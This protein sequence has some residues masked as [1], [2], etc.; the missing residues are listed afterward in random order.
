MATNIQETTLTFEFDPHL[1]GEDVRQDERLRNV[2]TGT[3]VTDALVA[4]FNGVAPLI[5][6]PAKSGPTIKLNELKVA[7]SFSVTRKFDAGLGDTIVLI[8]APD[9]DSLGPT[10][11]RSREQTSVYKLQLTIPLVLDTPP[12]S[13]R[14]ALLQP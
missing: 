2:E 7:V 3:F 12:D 13:R 11:S 6:R 14:I 10:A 8:P 9:L 1:S 4:S 5:R